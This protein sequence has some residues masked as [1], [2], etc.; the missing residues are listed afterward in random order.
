MARRKLR[1]RVFKQYEYLVGPMAGALK[2]RLP[3]SIELDDV[4]QAGK[5]GLWNATA[6]Y[7]PNRSVVITQKHVSIT[8]AREASFA[9]YARAK[10]R[11]AMLDS[12]K[13]KQWREAN[14][15]GLPETIQ[16]RDASPTVE[17][18]MIE[19]EEAGAVIAATSDRLRRVATAVQDTDPKF[20]P[21]SAKQKKVLK[22]RYGGEG[23]SQNAA[24]AIMG[25]RQ[26]SLHLIETRSI[27]I[28]RRKIAA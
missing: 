26:Q 8:E 6:N 24:A 28:L 19:R 25:I 3:P 21:M 13:G 1:E 20:L 18:Q 12:L 9:F 5:L 4:I 14:H 23:M 10:I 16:I 17:Q 15:Q 27:K 11:G 7:K 2:N 22:L